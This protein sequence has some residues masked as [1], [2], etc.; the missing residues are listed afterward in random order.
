MGAQKVVP[1]W[2]TAERRWAAVFAVAVLVSLVAVAASNPGLVQ[3]WPFTPAE[4]V[5][6]I[7]PLFLV[8]LFIERTLEV[9]LSAW[10]AGDSAQLEKRAKAAKAAPAGAG[11]ETE[12]HESELIHYKAG[13]QR[14]AFLGGITI[15]I[16]VS[17]LGI[18]A[19]GLFVDPAVFGKLPALQQSAFKVA[20]V[21]LTGAVLGGGADGLHKM[22][23]VFT[24]F[25]DTT[26][27]RAKAGAPE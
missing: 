7:T 15:G 6:Y 19:V 18:R 14:M 17:A 13:T 22:V 8:S 23:S 12:D 20:D 9:F 2:S 4:F 10:R 1:T 16:I 26:A 11:P 25:M 3:F 27:K 21:V 24:N 5:Q